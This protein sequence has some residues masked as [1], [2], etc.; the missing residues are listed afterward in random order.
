MAPDNAGEIRKGPIM[1]SHVMQVKKTGFQYEVSGDRLCGVG[2]E[3]LDHEVTSLD[4]YFRSRNS[5]LIL[6]ALRMGSRSD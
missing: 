2:I 6:C 1:K 3:T 4:V 5:T